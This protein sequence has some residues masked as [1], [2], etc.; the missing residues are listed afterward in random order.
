MKIVIL[1]AHVANP[2]DLSWDGLKAF[3]E[4]TVYPRTPAAETVARIGDAEAVYTNKVIIDRAV[5]EACPNLKFIG[6]LATGYNVVDI[7]A[8]RARGIAVCNIPAYST[9]DV[10]QMTFALLLDICFNVAKHSASVRA[11][12]WAACPD[13]SYTVSPLIELSGRTLGIIGYG[14]IGQAVSRVASAMGMYVLCNSRH[15]T[16]TDLPANCRYADLDEIFEKSDVISLHCPLNDSTKGIVN[17]ESIAR[18]KDGVIILNTGR[19]PLVV[20]QDLADALN[21]GKVYAAG[22]DVVSAEPISEDNPLLTAKNCVITP[23]IAWAP[24]AARERLVNIA[25]GNLAAWVKGAP[26][27]DVTRL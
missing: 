2:G 9:P 27:N 15:R 23:H 20:E 14:R 7:D 8:A 26:V 22:V 19:G 12:E 24:L 13:F 1:D 4:L 5:I 25:V 21:S 17:R 6:V 10:V 18:M 16:A 11:G 3:G